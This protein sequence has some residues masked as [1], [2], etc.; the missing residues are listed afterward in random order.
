MSA[1]MNSNM[2]NQRFGNSVIGTW[3]IVIPVCLLLWSWYYTSILAIVFGFISKDKIKQSNGFEK[4]DGLA[5]AGIILGFVGILFA[6]ISFVVSPA[7]WL[8]L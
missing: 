3:N 5:L 1:L 8:D 6:L 2:R 4:G 7:F